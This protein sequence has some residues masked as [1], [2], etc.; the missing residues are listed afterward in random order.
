MVVDFPRI[1]S[2]RSRTAS[3]TA[4]LTLSPVSRANSFAIR[5]VCSFLIFR[6]TILPFYHA[7]LPLYLMKHS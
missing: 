6:L 2:R 3:P 5:W 4:A 1:L 7:L